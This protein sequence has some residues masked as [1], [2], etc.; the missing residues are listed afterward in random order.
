MKKTEIK[1]FVSKQWGFKTNQITLLE[2]NTHYGELDYVMFE[3]CGIQYQARKE[4]A[5]LGQ[6]LW[7][8]EIYKPF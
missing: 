5:P 6:Q 7:D 4:M 8:F 2:T 3:V 1:S